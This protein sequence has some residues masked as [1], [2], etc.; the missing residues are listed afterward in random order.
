MVLGVGNILLS[1]EGLGVHAVNQLKR[2]CSFGD[3]LQ[4][5]DGGTL[6]IDLLYYMEGVDKLLIIDAVLGGGP[7]GTLY[8][9]KDHEVKSHFRKKVSAHEVGVQEVLALAELTGKK[10][11][12]IV[13]IG[14]EPFSFEVSTDLSDPVKEKM[15][16]LLMAV[17]EQLKNWGVEVRCHGDHHLG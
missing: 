12:E 2:N 13:L 8:L 3:D 1:D 15:P 9:L 4:L 10:P 14:M 6:G 5:L 16:E 11:A 7:P 17:I